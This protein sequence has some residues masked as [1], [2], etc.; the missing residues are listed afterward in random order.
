[1]GWNSIGDASRTVPLVIRWK[2]P[3]GENQTVS[4]PGGVD[5][6]IHWLMSYCCLKGVEL[7][8]PPHEGWCW[9]YFVKLIEGTDK[10]SNHGKG[11]GRAIDYNAPEN[12]RGTR[13]EM[14]LRLVQVFEENGFNWGGHW[15]FTD[16]MHFE[17]LR[18]RAWYAMRTRK[19]KRRVRRG[20]G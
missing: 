5:K 19:M 6:S 4:F 10:P 20:K 2:K 13:G 7:G 11:G 3:N 15:D 16:P 1:M 14:P 18:S 12:A 9:G 8:Y 17:A